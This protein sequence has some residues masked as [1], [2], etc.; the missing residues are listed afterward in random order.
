MIAPVIGILSG[1][2]LAAGHFSGNPWPLL[3]SHLIDI[4]LA[5][6]SAALLNGASNSLNQ[7]TDLEIDRKNKP[8]RPLPLGVISIQSAAIL[9]AILYISSMLLAY[10][11]QPDGSHAT[12]FLVTSGAL[13]TLIYSIPPFRTKRHGTLANLTIALARGLLLPMCG[14]SVV[15]G[16]HH[17]EPWIISSAFAIFIFGA[18]TTKDFSDAAG[19]AEGDC[20][21]WVVKYGNEKAA[22]LVRPFLVLPWL[23]LAALWTLPVDQPIL[24]NGNITIALCLSTFLAGYGLWIGSLLQKNISE[25]PQAENH[26]SWKHIY[27]QYQLALI[28]VP[29]IYLI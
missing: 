21:T 9:S 18:A 17:P 26:S 11:I 2:F 25:H 13:L 29:C 16:V 19:D 27:L 28:G 14:W 5:V 24:P 22:K 10:T 4:L 8:A 23:L 15:A 6:G 12:F 1:A 7:I 20:Q 3:N